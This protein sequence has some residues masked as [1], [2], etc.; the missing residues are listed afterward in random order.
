MNMLLG[1]FLH[2]HID[3][4]FRKCKCNTMFSFCYHANCSFQGDYYWVLYAI[5]KC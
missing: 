1:R 4:A 3:F 5:F 2:T